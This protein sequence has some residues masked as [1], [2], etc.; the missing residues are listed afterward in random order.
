MNDPLDEINSRL[1]PISVLSVIQIV[2]SLISI[3]VFRHLEIDG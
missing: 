3:D 1:K 2:K